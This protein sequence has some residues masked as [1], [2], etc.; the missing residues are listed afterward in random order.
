M[1]QQTTVVNSFVYV[2][3][4]IFRITSKLV[5]NKSTINV[6]LYK[7]DDGI[8]LCVSLVVCFIMYLFLFCYLAAIGVFLRF[9]LI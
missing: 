8:Y 2:C 3:N 1:K 4:I 5:V 9:L 7:Y 6:I